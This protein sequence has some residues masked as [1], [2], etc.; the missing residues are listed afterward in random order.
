MT[1]QQITLLLREGEEKEFTQILVG[2]GCES[3]PQ[4]RGGRAREEYDDRTQVTK[5]KHCKLARTKNS[6][7]LNYFCIDTKT[8]NLS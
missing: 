5:D 1:I 3:G 6:C 7:D 2:F 8:G 4:T